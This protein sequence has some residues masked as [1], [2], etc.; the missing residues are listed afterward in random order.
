MFLFVCIV[1]FGLCKNNSNAGTEARCGGGG[2]G[3]R[4]GRVGRGGWSTGTPP[5]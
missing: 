2:G 3:G 1:G 5:Q 4:G